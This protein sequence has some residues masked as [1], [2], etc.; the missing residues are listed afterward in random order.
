MQILNSSSLIVLFTFLFQQPAQ[1]PLPLIREN[2][3]VKV[4]EHVYVIPDGNV[5]AVPNVGIIVGSKATLVIDTGL[6]LR[7]GQTVLREVQKVS[8]NADIIIVS[9]HF[10]AE[11]T[12]G[13]SAFPPTAKVIRAKAEQQDIDEFGVQPN[14]AARS[15]ALAE[16]VK[17]AQFRRADEIFDSEKTLDLGGVRARLFW[18]GGT[19]TNGDTLIYIEGDNVL[20]A[21]DVIMNRRFLG[22]NSPRSSVQAWINSLDKVAPLHPARIVPSHGEM[23]DGSLIETNRTYL[24]ALQTRVAEL[25]R[26]GKTVDEVAEAMTAEFKAKYPDWTGN[27]GAAARI[28]YNEAK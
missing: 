28:A 15:P 22:F 19:H 21:G 17:D 25:K 13:E 1:A 20:F 18:Y 12:L 6:G 4:A 16:L 11:H 14:F 7:N 9:T 8:R 2:V 27:A 26:A 23:G 3:T 5:G 10:H 24:R